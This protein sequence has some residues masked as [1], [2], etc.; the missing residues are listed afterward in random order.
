[1]SLEIDTHWECMFDGVM[2]LPS[3]KST[4]VC[5]QAKHLSVKI[6]TEKNIDIKN[7]SAYLESGV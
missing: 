2:E 3:L 6:N 5:P 7:S 1:M 4:F